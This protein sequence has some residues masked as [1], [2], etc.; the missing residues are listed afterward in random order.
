MCKQIEEAEETRSRLEEQE[1]AALQKELK[2]REKVKEDNVAV[3][4]LRAQRAAVLQSVQ[5]LQERR[6]GAC[7]SS[8]SSPS[9][10]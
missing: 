1:A 9:P 4:E 3:G 10:L 8:P 2:M 6:V 7:C 5:T